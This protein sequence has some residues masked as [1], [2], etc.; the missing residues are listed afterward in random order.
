MEG[1]VKNID[2]NDVVHE[3]ENETPE[4]VDI[5]Q[6]FQVTL[7]VGNHE[8]RVWGIHK[9]LITDEVCPPNRLGQRHHGKVKYEQKAQ[10]HN[11][12]V[13]RL[14]EAHD[15]NI[16]SLHE[17]HTIDESDQQEDQR[18]CVHDGES[19]EIDGTKEQAPIFVTVFLG[20]DFLW[21]DVVP[22]GVLHLEEETITLKENDSNIGKL[23][24]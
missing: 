10:K 13:Y 17:T 19:S 4:Q 1:C 18:K 20:Q 23:L 7:W 24:L 14:D 16:Q 11:K 6:E 21:V 5:K 22:K 12:Q 15:N 3:H 9:R 8:H 2:S